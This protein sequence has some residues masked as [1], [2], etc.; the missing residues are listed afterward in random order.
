M[1]TVGK[2]HSS[3]RKVDDS[4]V[5]LLNKIVLR[6]TL[7]MEYEVRRKSGQVMPLERG[8]KLL[9]V[10]SK[11]LHRS[12]ERADLSSFTVELGKDSRDWDL[13]NDLLLID[14]LEERC[15]WEVE[16]EEEEW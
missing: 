11:V 14:V 7:D 15:R 3:E 16:R 9:Q 12:S 13:R 5:L 10:I 1:L 4:R 8:A 2:L 6:E